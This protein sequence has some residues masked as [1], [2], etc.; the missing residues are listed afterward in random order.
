MDL[1]IITRIND[2]SKMVDGNQLTSSHSHR[3][4]QPIVERQFGSKSSKLVLAP[5]EVKFSFDHSNQT[6]LELSIDICDLH[7]ALSSLS[8]SF[9][10]GWAFNT[11][12]CSL[13]KYKQFN[14]LRSVLVF[15]FSSLMEDKKFSAILWQ[16]YPPIDVFL[17]LSFQS[18]LE[19][20]TE[21]LVASRNEIFS[22]LQVIQF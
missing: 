15:L 8:L 19:E 18:I 20:T 2:I 1:K 16:T 10:P 6:S 12:T 13:L 17:W 21:L 22:F 11:V 3:N 9:E 4:K 7:A 14:A 5:S